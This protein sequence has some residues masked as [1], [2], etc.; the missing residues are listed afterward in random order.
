MITIFKERNK[1]MEIMRF[2]ALFRRTPAHHPE[3]ENMLTDIKKKQSEINGEKQV[4][5]PLGFLDEQ[6]Y[7]I[8]HNLR[9][10]DDHGS[11]QMDTLLLVVNLNLIIEV[12]NWQGTVI[13]GENGQVT[14][15]TPDGREEGFDNP[16]TQVRTQV[17]RLQKW[18]Q[19]N[20]FPVMP[21]EYVV[22]ISHPKTMIT[23]SSPKVKIPHEV[24][25]NNELFFRIQALE[26]KHT[27]RNVSMEQLHN[28]AN[29]LK[30][31]HVP[32]RVNLLEKYH[33]HP[34]NLIKGVFCPKCG[35][36]PMMRN[37]QQWF[38]SQCEH[39]DD[40]AHISALNDY[41]LIL[42]DKI[43][44]REARAFLRI[45][46]RD[47]MKRLMKKGGYNLLGFKKGSVYELKLKF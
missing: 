12:K 2:D 36:L 24:I 4:D 16:V 27:K 37:R 1:Q 41:M 13:F 21:F 46:S 28:M 22:V 17:H 25:H 3:K 39:Y 35:F 33:I 26:E 6:K 10:P 47:V 43:T 8:L 9:L 11:F 31:A 15:R 32:P 23:T 45:Q 30:A 18:F 44:N 7:F 38:C 29:R 40:A 19:K 20:N 34:D 14:R 42:G 5:Y